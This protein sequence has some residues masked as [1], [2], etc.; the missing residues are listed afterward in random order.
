M[1]ANGS[2]QKDERPSFAPPP[3]IKPRP[4]QDQTWSRPN[5]MQRRAIRTRFFLSQ[6]PGILTFVIIAINVVVYLVEA[7]LSR[8][9][10]ISS[11]VLLAMGAQWTP[12]IQQTGEYWRIFTAM[13]LHGNLIHIGLNMLSLYFIGRVVEMVFG[14]WRYLVIYFASG[15]VGGII[16][17]FLA[18]NIPVVGASGAIFG[19]FGALGAFY[20]VNRHALG[21]YGRGAIMNWVFW[22]ALNLVWNISSPGLSITD[23]IGG[24]VA[25]LILGI[26]LIPRLGRRRI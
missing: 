11:D 25:G 17:Y 8:N 6:I 10:N 22:L 13:F 15:I 24:L 23:H 14:P 7:L 12:L 19:V 21:A 3:E 2:T 18:P 26:V 16:T 9:L 20:I 4:S 1:P 5:S